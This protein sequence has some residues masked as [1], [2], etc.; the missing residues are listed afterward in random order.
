MIWRVILVQ[1]TF[2]MRIFYGQPCLYWQLTK[3]L[4]S[5]RSAWLICT[6]L[7]CDWFVCFYHV[8]CELG[9]CD[10]LSVFRDLWCICPK[11]VV[12]SI[13]LKEFS[14][15]PLSRNW[16][17]TLISVLTGIPDQGP[18]WICINLVRIQNKHLKQYDCI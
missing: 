1:R 8:L 14:E 15:I 9:M 10:M 2:L 5:H 16:K 18:Q 12:W 17:V 13:L 4:F 11:L 3:Q 7:I 6:W